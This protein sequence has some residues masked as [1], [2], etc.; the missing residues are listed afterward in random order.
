MIQWKVLRVERN[1]VHVAYG[2]ITFWVEVKADGS[3]LQV[4]KPSSVYIDGPDFREMLDL[5]R[6]EYL[7]KMVN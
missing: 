5:V 4:L 3:R 1:A 6:K 2:P 7:R